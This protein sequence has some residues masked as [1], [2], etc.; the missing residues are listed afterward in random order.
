MSRN[1]PEIGSI[2][3]STR[4]RRPV[5]R[6]R[7]GQF[8]H[9]RVT[10]RFVHAIAE[11]VDTRALRARA[12]IAIKGA[13][14]LVGKKAHDSIISILIVEMMGEVMLLQVQQEA[15]LWLI[16]EMLDAVDEF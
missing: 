4:R 9:P 13:G 7:T 14:Q 16:V 12:R 5:A 6:R 15:A 10:A 1:Q 3:G 2:A 8:H 11:I